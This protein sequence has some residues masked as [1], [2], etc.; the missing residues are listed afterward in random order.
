[1]VF[2]VWGNTSSPIRGTVLNEQVY[3]SLLTAL[4][5]VCEQIPVIP[6]NINLAVQYMKI[7]F[8]QH[9]SL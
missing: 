1:M 6:C 5:K 4:Q 3:E 7:L 2:Y 9:K 8:P